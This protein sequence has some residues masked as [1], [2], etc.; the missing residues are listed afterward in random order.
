MVL[1]NLLSDVSMDTNCPD[2]WHCDYVVDGLFPVRTLA[3]IV[4]DKWA[5]H[6]SIPTIRQRL[7]PQKVNVFLWRAQRDFLPCYLQLAV[8]R[9]NIPSLLCPL[10]SVECESTYHA[11]L[12]CDVVAKVWRIVVK[13]CGVQRLFL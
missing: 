4:G 12:R 6:S 5:E 8:R 11:L 13:W 10:C 1:Q 3:A 9:L 2:S 7:L